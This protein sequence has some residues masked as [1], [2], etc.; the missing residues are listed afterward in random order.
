MIGDKET[1]K[2][3]CLLGKLKELDPDTWEKWFNDYDV[4]GLD[5]MQLDNLQGCLQRACAERG[6]PVVISFYPPEGPCKG[7][8]RAYIWHTLRCTMTRGDTLVPTLLAAYLRA[9]KKT[10]KVV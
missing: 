9:V 6:W 2:L 8:Y 1:E 10:E 4:Y 7:C 3:V 5:D